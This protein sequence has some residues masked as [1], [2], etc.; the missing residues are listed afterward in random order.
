[1]GKSWITAA[2]VLWRLYCD[3]QVNILVVSASKQ[4]AD[5]FTTFCLQLIDEVPVLSFLRPRDDQRRSKIEFD[6]SPAE[7]DQNPSVRSAGIT[8]QITGSRAD[9]IVADDIEVP[10]NSA[11]P[12]L[13]EKL[14]EGVKEFDSIL[15]PLPTSR[16]TFLGTPQTEESI[17][18][19][20]AKRDYKARIW[21]ARYPDAKQRAGYGD[22]LAPDIAQEA[23]VEGA[24]TEPT[25][26]TDNDLSEREMSLG[27]ST[28]SLQFML[29]TSFSDSDKYPLKLRDLLIAPLDPRIAHESM[30]WSSL[31]EWEDTALPRV[32][33]SG[34]RL[35][36]PVYIKDI[37]VLP[38][39]GIVMSID[40]SGRGKDETAY[41][42]VAILH[43]TLYLLASGGFRDGYSEATLTGLANVAAKYKVNS[44]I[45]EANYGD[46]MFTSILKPV[47]AK[48]HPCMIEEIKHNIQ[49]EKRIIDTLEPVM[50]QHRL[51]V[52]RDLY[53]KDTEYL[54]SDEHLAPQRYQLFHQMTRITK[55]K[56]C[57]SQDDR[58]DALAMAVA[59]WVQHMAAD[60]DK[61]VAKSREKAMEKEL[62]RFM[63]HALGPSPRKG[64]TWASRVS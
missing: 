59:Y 20:L 29:D 27:R 24:S 49:K 56:A 58:L 1:V 3:P 4:R 61:L 62:K 10:A 31:P 45:T 52:D 60:R 25:R 39:S 17:Y 64:M 51:V 44:I 50:N 28:F 5:N 16:V 8:G 7:P 6:V 38:Y 34:D 30:M 19:E 57:L 53:L 13:R 46:G 23:G 18:N 33:L 41:A 11:T 40:P 36:R 26:F 42:V 47:M 48:I 43:S 9:E 15:K 35:Y 21:P 14:A 22:K 2:Y 12:M 54:I 55:E 63:E 32:G 37:P